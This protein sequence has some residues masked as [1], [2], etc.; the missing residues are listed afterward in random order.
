MGSSLPAPLAD[1]V[2]QLSKLPGLGPKSA[3]RAAMALLKWPESE[4]RRL[5][6]EIC[7]LRDKLRLC[8]RCGSLSA[9]DP[10]RICSDAGRDKTLL[11]VVPEWDSLLALEEG[12]FYDGL[13]F[14]LGGLLAPLEREGASGPDL[15]P[16]K[17]RLGEGDV[18][19]VILA[20]GATLEGENTATWVS[21]AIKKDFP[22]IKVSRL[23]QGMPLGAEVRFMDR[24]TLRQ[25]L[26]Y[27]QEI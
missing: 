21:Q 22:S 8:S 3:M 20:L 17:E 1:L 2:G 13:Y 24:E 10:C 23:A 9:E 19:E 12:L 27:R 4:T 7:A 11:C 6:E 15:Q 16:L 14:V 5:G 26:R 25:S 18:R